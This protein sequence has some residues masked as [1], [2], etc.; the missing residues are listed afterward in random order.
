[1]KARN[2]PLWR[3]KTGSRVAGKRRSWIIKFFNDRLQLW[4]YH[5][6]DDP[7]HFYIDLWLNWEVAHHEE[8][9]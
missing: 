6:Y 4:H 5:D 1:M 8:G 9:Q 2:I 7:R 3:D